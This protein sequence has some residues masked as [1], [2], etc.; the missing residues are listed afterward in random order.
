MMTPHSLICRFLAFA[1]ILCL[2]TSLTA[3]GSWTSAQRRSG[4]RE[5]QRSFEALPATPDLYTVIELERVRVHIVGDRSLFSAP[6]AAAY[7]SPILAYATPGN[8]IWLIG[9]RV[10]GL[11]VIN[12]AILGHELQHLLNFKNPAI[13]D[14]DQLDRLGM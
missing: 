10:N 1:A 13:A 14:P 9:K 2:L 5:I 12:Q 6:T 8:A 7:G 11:I 3:C 4:F